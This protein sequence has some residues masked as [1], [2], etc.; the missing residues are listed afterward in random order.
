MYLNFMR[1]Q[2]IQTISLPDKIKGRFNIEDTDGKVLL[3][4][5]GVEDKWILNSTNLAT[6]MN[7]DG[8]EIDKLELIENKMIQVI[9]TKDEEEA[10]VFVENQTDDKSTFK[11]YFFPNNVVITI[12]RTQDNII[13]Y[14]NEYVSSNHAKI[15]VLNDEIIVTD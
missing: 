7:Q 6:A 12:G 15:N 8:E 2:T 1:N 13:S 4:V 11:K 3:V 9:L 5:E 14:K 10:S